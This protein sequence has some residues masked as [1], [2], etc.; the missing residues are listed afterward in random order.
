MRAILI[1][2][3]KKTVTEIQLKSDDYREIRTVLQCHSYTT[4]AHLGGSIAKGFDAVFVSD[5]PLEERG[6]PRFW[7]QV[8]ANREPPSSFPIAGRGLALGTD[9]KGNGCDVRIGVAELASRITF[10]QRK[11]RGFKFSSQIYADVTHLSVDVVAPI[12]D[13]K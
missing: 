6:D 2:P 7:F 13:N 8:D 12:V 1:E 9:S 3:K 11:F 10:T 5:D 4:G